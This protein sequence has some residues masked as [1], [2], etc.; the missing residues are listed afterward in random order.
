MGW[1]NHSGHRSESL[2]RCVDFPVNNPRVPRHQ[3]TR[4][5]HMICTGDVGGIL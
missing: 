4:N 1:R 3:S 5:D 2:C